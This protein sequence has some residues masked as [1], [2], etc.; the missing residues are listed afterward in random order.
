[1]NK[2]MPIGDMGN[3]HG[4]LYVKK[5][6]TGHYWSIKTQDGHYW[7]RISKP[8]Y[9]ELIRHNIMFDEKLKQITK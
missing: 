9:D 6:E 3:D 1:M 4:R 5:T 7:E 8:L 2:A